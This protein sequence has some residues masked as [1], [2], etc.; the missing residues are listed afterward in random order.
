M[1]TTSTTKPPASRGR[2]F[3]QPTIIRL[4]KGAGI[5][6]LGAILIGLILFLTV[7]TFY[8]F[9]DSWVRPMI[10]SPQHEKVVAAVTA[11]ADA[12]LAKSR[13]DGERQEAAAELVQIDRAVA[14]G[15]KFEADV[16]AVGAGP[17]KDANA[18]LLRR[19]LD[20][21]AL[22]RAAAGDRKEALTRRIA[23]LD[24]RVAEQDALLERLRASPYLKAAAG[25]V[26]IAFVPYENLEKVHPGVSL[27][28]CQWGLVRCEYVG[29]VTSILDGE[30]N[31][32]HPHDGSP[33]RGVLAEVELSN[34][35]AAE[36]GVLFA[37]HKPFYLF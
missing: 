22:E 15:L 30:V 23:D 12:K 34:P 14:A 18:G 28:G 2:L 11:E 13:L 20:R 35:K 9:N 8:F 17:I 33:K 16:G 32:T 36:W 19:E 29:K 21:S 24:T 6:A 27:Y 7:N 26:V 1:T 3:L 10:L 4:Y 25:R 31:D 5:A 37:G